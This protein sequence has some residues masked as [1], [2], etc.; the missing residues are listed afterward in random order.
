MKKITLILSIFRVCNFYSN[1]DLI[2][3]YYFFNC[4][5]EVTQFRS[6]TGDLPMVQWR[7]LCMKETIGSHKFSSSVWK[8]EKSLLRL[9]KTSTCHTVTCFCFRRIKFSLSVEK[10]SCQSSFAFEFLLPS[11][12]RSFKILRRRVFSILRWFFKAFVIS[13]YFDMP[14]CFNVLCVQITKTLFNFESNYCF[15][16]HSFCHYRKKWVTFNFLL[17]TFWAIFT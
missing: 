7:N 16:F 5:A 10:T 12:A 14:I 1:N 2:E 15:V 13:S 6:A 8:L 17:G 11:T 4:D 3:N 9:S